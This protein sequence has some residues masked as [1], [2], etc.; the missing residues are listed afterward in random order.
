MD[1]KTLKFLAKVLENRSKF[2]FSCERSC[3]S[4]ERPSIEGR[5]EE[6]KDFLDYIKKSLKRNEKRI[7]KQ[8]VK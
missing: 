3:C 5:K 1:V 7:K 8:E 2:L 6:N 4:W